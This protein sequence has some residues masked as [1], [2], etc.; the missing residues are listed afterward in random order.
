MGT[1]FVGADWAGLVLMVAA[2][3]LASA[4]APSSTTSER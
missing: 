1:Q 3:F 2:V 4:G